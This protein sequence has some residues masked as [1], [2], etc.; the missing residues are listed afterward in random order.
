MLK[1]LF[2]VE[3]SKKAPRN[4]LKMRHSLWTSPVANFYS[5]LCVFNS[6]TTTPRHRNDSE[7]YKRKHVSL[8]SV[9][10]IENKIL[11]TDI[12]MKVPD[13][14]LS[15]INDGRSECEWEMKSRA[16][17]ENSS[18]KFQCQA[19]P[20]RVLLF[21]RFTFFVRLSFK[22][23][24]RRRD[25]NIKYHPDLIVDWRER[26]TTRIIECSTLRAIF[27]NTVFLFISIPTTILGD[28]TVVSWL[29][30][31]LTLNMA[32]F[33]RVSLVSLVVY[34]TLRR[35]IHPNIGWTAKKLRKTVLK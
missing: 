12:R 10:T 22:K 27:T 6:C 33:I 3:P 25:E 31:A 28:E 1:T 2:S 13:N 11:K 21:Q 4:L 35:C 8:L 14:F 9:K 32:W 20:F 30:P 23:P 24:S 19:E 26:L 5:K 17:S 15:A 7:I 29:W 18:E 34:V 16:I